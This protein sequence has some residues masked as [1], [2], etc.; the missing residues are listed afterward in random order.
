MM[1]EVDSL[2]ASAPATHAPPLE[3]AIDL[4]IWAV[5]TGQEDAVMAATLGAMMTLL[6][7]AALGQ[8][9]ALM[10]FL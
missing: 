2:L 9:I 4:L 10:V 8:F 3:H 7:L 1:P 5:Q 6:P